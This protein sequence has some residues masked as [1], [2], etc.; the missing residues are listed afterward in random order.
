[1]RLHFLIIIKAKLHE[2]LWNKHTISLLSIQLNFGN[3]IVKYAIDLP[4]NKL[5]ASVLQRNQGT[6]INLVSQLNASHLREVRL[7][8]IYFGFFL[9][10]ISIYCYLSVSK[11][12]PAER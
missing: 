10:V 11:S 2:R 1:M 6:L 7:E 5:W 8:S 3:R 4:V 12:V 9:A